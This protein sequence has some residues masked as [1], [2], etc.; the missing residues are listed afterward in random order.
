MTPSWAWEAMTGTRHRG[1]VR[2]LDEYKAARENERLLGEFFEEGLPELDRVGIWLR[3]T[4]VWKETRGWALRA[5]SPASVA[6]LAL[7]SLL[8]VYVWLKTLVWPDSD[9]L[10]LL[11]GGRNS[12]LYLARRK[13]GREDSDS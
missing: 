6:G 4:W 3:M 7:F 11:L 12:M 2:E 13:D 9:D 8:Y 10:R 5:G 1:L